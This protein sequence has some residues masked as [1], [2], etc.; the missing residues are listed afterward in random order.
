MVHNAESLANAVCGNCGSVDFET[1]SRGPAVSLANWVES[2]ISLSLVYSSLSGVSG[3]SRAVNEP[4]G[5][6][7]RAWNLLRNGGSRG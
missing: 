5:S 2:T 1:A 4:T 6:M 7:N 3:T